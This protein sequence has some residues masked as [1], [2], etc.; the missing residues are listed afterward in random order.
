MKRSAWTSLLGMLRL[1]RSVRG[2]VLLCTFVMILE[3]ASSLAF[4]FLSKT[5]V[6]LATGGAQNPELVRTVV[7]MAL[8]MLLQIV[9]RVWSGYLEGKTLIVAKNRIREEVFSRAMRSTWTGKE[10]FHSADIVNRLERDIEELCNFVCSTLPFFFVILAE[11]ASSCIFVFALSPSLAWVLVFIMPMA[12]FASRL[13]FKKQRSLTSRI[14]GIDARIQGHMQEHLQHRALDLTM[15]AVEKVQDSL[16]DLQQD[17]KDTTIERLRYSSF[18]RAVMQAGFAC[19][20]LVAFLWGVFG[21]RS[22]AV[23]YGVM[24]AFLQ[25]VGKVQRPVAQMAS[26]IPA[27]IRAVASEERVNDLLVLDQEDSLRDIKYEGKLGVSLEGVSFAYPEGPQIL[28]NLSFDFRPGTFNAIVGPTGTGK[29]TLVKMVLSLLKP[30]S[31]SIQIYSDS[32]RGPCNAGTRCNFMYVP[33]GN[34]LLSGTIRDNLLLAAPF[35]TQEE[36][37]AALEMA[38]ATFVLDLPKGLD[39]EIA[40]VGSGLSEGQCQRISIARAL[41]RPGGILILDEA[42]SALDSETEEKVL[43]NICE[44]CKGER[45]VL[46]ITHRPAATALADTT[47]SL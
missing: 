47:L 36:M 16:T 12:V 25:L 32:Q 13:F 4:V 33:Q 18:S 10:R 37:I 45:T 27:F 17:E 38:C 15:G 8:V 29:S 7:A 23:S 2:R 46:C 1:G 42:T 11:F 24:V 39:S 9:C 28:S 5:I 19:G 14:R 21:L 41:L 30:Q 26:C 43:G 31:G 44:K 40:E 35:A 20:Y 3:V 22:G 34:T 6:D